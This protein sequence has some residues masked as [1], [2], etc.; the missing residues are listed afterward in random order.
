MK[1]PLLSKF[2]TD[3]GKKWTLKLSMSF[4]LMLIS[5]ILTFGAMDLKKT[6]VKERNVGV[7]TAVSA[8]AWCDEC[9]CKTLESIGQKI[10][11]ACKKCCSGITDAIQNSEIQFSQYGYDGLPTMNFPQSRNLM[12]HAARG[13]PK[14]VSRLDGDP[15][16]SQAG[17][18]TIT[19][20]DSSSGGAS[21]GGVSSPNVL[22]LNTK[23]STMPQ[24]PPRSSTPLNDVEIKVQMQVPGMGPRIFDW[25]TFIDPLKTVEDV[26]NSSISSKGLNIKYS[27]NVVT[28]M[29]WNGQSH[30]FNYLDVLTKP[31]LQ[32]VSSPMEIKFLAK[33]FNYNFKT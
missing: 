13:F 33:E 28:I 21:P 24:T 10:M 11:E 32:L 15:G 3:S 30:Q 25:D 22:P 31:V 4:A 29:D 23:A 27:K 16:P 2:P 14:S 5:I 20:A 6:K 7:L 19:S 8:V 12:P 18:F 9:T 1:S 26:A 17:I